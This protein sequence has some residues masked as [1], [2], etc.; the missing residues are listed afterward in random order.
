MC[1]S[2]ACSGSLISGSDSCKL[3]FGFDTISV[4]YL[5]IPAIVNCV[6][7]ILL[8]VLLVVGA[9][10]LL[11]LSIK[12]NP[13]IIDQQIHIDIEAVLLILILSLPLLYIVIFSFCRVNKSHLQLM[14]FYCQR[15]SL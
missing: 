4:I 12:A 15:Y 7:S 5:L 11:D 2:V 9:E 10:L 6:S 1:H 3:I 13:N 14:I 8:I